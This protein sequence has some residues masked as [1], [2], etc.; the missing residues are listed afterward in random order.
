[1]HS[2]RKSGRQLGDEK[3]REN[4]VGLDLLSLRCLWAMQQAIPLGVEWMGLEFEG[5]VGPR[6]SD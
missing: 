3:A 2:V 4:E 5:E 1:M 6:V